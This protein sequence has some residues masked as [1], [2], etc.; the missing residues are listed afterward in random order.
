DPLFIS[1]IDSTSA[2]GGQISVQGTSVTY[3]GVARR[4]TDTFTYTA[5]DRFL[6]SSATVS[7]TLTNG[8]PVATPVTAQV[9][10][11]GTVNVVG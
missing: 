3:R 1:A 8:V 5:S 10:W 11:K 2:F 9:Q 4:G 7:V 6:S